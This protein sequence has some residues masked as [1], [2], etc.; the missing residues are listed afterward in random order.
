MSSPN[1]VLLRGRVS[2]FVLFSSSNDWMRLTT[3]G[4][5]ICF[6]Q[7]LDLDVNLMEKHAHRNTQYNV[8]LYLGTL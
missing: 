3:F 4:R 6:T 8:L 7:P 1:F 5:A 2:L